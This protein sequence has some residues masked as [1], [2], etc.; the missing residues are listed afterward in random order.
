M[1]LE[2]RGIVASTWLD[3]AVPMM[4]QNSTSCLPCSSAS[5]FPLCHGFSVWLDSC[6]CVREVLVSFHC[7]KE[8]ELCPPRLAVD[9]G[10]ETTL[11]SWSLKIA[12]RRLGD[13]NVLSL[14]WLGHMPMPEQKAS[15]VPLNPK[16]VISERIKCYWKERGNVKS[17]MHTLW[18]LNHSRKYF[19][20]VCR[21]DTLGPCVQETEKPYQQSIPS[22]F[23]TFLTTFDTCLGFINK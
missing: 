6:T 12:S 1:K 22:T 11:F 7:P 23:V 8:R 19:V 20:T 2:S 5:F 4:S 14:I 15:I 10:K 17:Q 18:I 9:S 21:N 3:V 13:K 16:K